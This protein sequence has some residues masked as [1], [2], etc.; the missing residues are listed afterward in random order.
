MRPPAIG[1]HG[2]AEAR[3]PVR[4]GFDRGGREYFLRSAGTERSRCSASEHSWVA[5][6]RS[7]GVHLEA[8]ATRHVP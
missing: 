3:K 4:E 6:Q 2:L 5:S 7:V 8:P 1:S